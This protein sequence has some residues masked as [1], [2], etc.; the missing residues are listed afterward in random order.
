[1]DQE[2]KFG[3]NI[4]LLSIMTL[5]TVIVWVGYEVY[6]AYTQ[7]TV[8]RVIKE[9]IR[10]LSPSIDEATIEDIKGKYQIPEEELNIVTQPVVEWETEEEEEIE[11]EIETEEEATPSQTPD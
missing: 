7:T 3:K 4:L 11:E 8:P 2:Y 10:P 6:S 9:L 1:M 5:I